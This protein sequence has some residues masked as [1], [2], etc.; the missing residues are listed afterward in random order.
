MLEAEPVG[1]SNG[2]AETELI[3]ESAVWFLLS[4]G[5]WARAVEVA[6]VVRN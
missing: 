2:E 5:C 3:A 1:E 6:M 4:T